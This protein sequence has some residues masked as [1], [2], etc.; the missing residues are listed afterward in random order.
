MTK[1]GPKMPFFWPM[2]GPWR[3]LIANL[4]IGLRNFA[5]TAAKK[6]SAKKSCW[7]CEN[8]G[9]EKSLFDS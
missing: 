7:K 9:P 1:I 6:I 4:K 8:P 3:V 2:L 5:K